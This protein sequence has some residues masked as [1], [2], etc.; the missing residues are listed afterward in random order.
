MDWTGSEKLL[1]VCNLRSRYESVFL[2][3]HFSRLSCLQTRLHQPGWILWAEQAGWKLKTKAGR[4]TP[5][6]PKGSEQISANI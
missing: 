3:L 1:P 5:M 2:S 4:L 6:I